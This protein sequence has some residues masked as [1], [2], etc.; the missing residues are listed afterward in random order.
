MPAI[1]VQYSKAEIFRISERCDYGYTGA[2]LKNQNIS[3]WR[4]TYNKSENDR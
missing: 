3:G 2:I 1:Q 4:K